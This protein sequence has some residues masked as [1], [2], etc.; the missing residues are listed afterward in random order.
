[1]RHAA[2][3][4]EVLV[5]HTR[6]GELLRDLV[7]LAGLGTLSA[8][9][10]MFVSRVPY[11]N[12]TYESSLVYSA[13]LPRA[14][15]AADLVL[16]RY[17]QA[18]LAPESATANPRVLTE[19]VNVT[20]LTFP[21]ASL[22]TS[23]RLLGGTLKAGHL[24]TDG[25]V[26][27]E[28]TAARFE[29]A[30][31]DSVTLW[32]PT[33]DAAS[34]G[35]VDICGVGGPWHPDESLGSRGYVLAPQGLLASE[36]EGF[37]GTLERGATSYWMNAVPEG[38]TSHA[39]AVRAIMGNDLA[40]SAFVWSII[41][42]GLMLWVTGVARAAQSLRSSLAQP[43]SVLSSVGTGPH[44]AAS[45][46]FTVVALLSLVASWGAAL[47]ARWVVLAWTSLYITT[48]QIVLVSAALSVVGLVEIGFLA[49]RYAR[50]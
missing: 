2:I 42:L 21:D 29:V 41:L 43:W 31:G 50:T 4:W 45:Y 11:D 49:R 32:W 7:V 34:P 1:M 3:A 37:P 28:A 48:S 47:F 6:V 38:A 9:A 20:V 36:F 14:E 25:V 40:L 15:E 44:A 18:D 19:S 13:R 39:E 33:L 46:L 24:C 30:P 22:P 10:V 23:D 17:P 16:T 5:R 8:F 35:R 26:V 27:D 12:V